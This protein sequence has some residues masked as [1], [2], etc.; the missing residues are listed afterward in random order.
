[1]TPSL[2][3]D[4]IETGNDAPTTASGRTTTRMASPDRRPGFRRRLSGRPTPAR[5]QRP[6]TLRSPLVTAASEVVRSSRSASPVTSRP[7]GIQQA[8]R[9]ALIRRSWAPLPAGS[10]RSRAGPERVLDHFGRGTASLSDRGK[11]VVLAA[12]RSRGSWWPRSTSVSRSCLD[13]YHQFREGEAGDAEQRA[14]RRD[15][16][17]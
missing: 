15:A 10:G 11:K 5:A 9:Y 8:R 14:G 12:P 1:M 3:G 13:L 2:C 16:R 4:Y 7:A 17:G 6:V